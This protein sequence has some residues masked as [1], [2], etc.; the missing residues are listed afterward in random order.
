MISD[1]QRVFED[2]LQNES[3]YQQIDELAKQYLVKS[4]E[5]ER[6]EISQGQVPISTTIK[7]ADNR[8]LINARYWWPDQLTVNGLVDH[9]RTWLNAWAT[10]PA[11]QKNLS[12]VA[13]R[14][15]GKNM[16]KAGLN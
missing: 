10:L 8:K 4:I 11:G 6:Q 16:E 5:I 15:G 12:N 14:L 9:I 3:L 2:D 7:D 1:R 13:A